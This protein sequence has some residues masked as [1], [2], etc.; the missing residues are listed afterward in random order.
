VVERQAEPP[1][2]SVRPAS[3][4][5]GLGVMLGFAA[6]VL[7]AA[8]I[9][10]AYLLTHRS[11]GTQVT[12]MT[13]AA[14]TPPKAKPPNTP[15]RFVPIPNL[16]GQ[17]FAV[18]QTRLDTLGFNVAERFVSS[19]QPEGTVVDQAPK[20]ANRGAK[21]A[22]ITLVVAKAGPITT[23]AAS[24]TTQ[25]P[26]ST[27][28]T[29]IAAPTQASVPSLAGQSE[30]AA[31]TALYRNGILASLVYVPAH[32]PLGTVEAQAKAAGTPV[33]YHSH[34]QINLSRGPGD[35]ANHAV[36]NTV[37]ETLDQALATINS[38]KL[39]LIYVR[40]PVS[41]RAEAGKIIEQSP[42]AGGSAPEN[43]QILLFLGAYGTG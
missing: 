24:T 27:T 4:N 21:G 9:G 20:A 6:V 41:S 43:A 36:P 39:R 1:P 40:L 18:A 5:F 22:L 16:L 7:V 12:T 38:A 8:G 32:D 17:S 26:T 30:Q 35:K 14:V 19:H 10:I 28:A 29:T 42:L 37:G 33:A 11:A 2:P 34:M 13:V 15:A 3:G 23:V 25:H 31:V